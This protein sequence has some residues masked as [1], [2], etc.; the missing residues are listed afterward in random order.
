MSGDVRRWLEV[1]LGAVPDSFVS[2]IERYA[3]GDGG[4][5]SPSRDG[6][7]PSGGPEAGLS[8]ELGDRGVR[9]LR[10]ALERPGRD[11]EAA[12]RLLAADAYLTWAC[13]AAVE[14]EEPEAAL[15]GL[16]DRVAA[17]WE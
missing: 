4:V 8:R 16:L 2:W 17:E 3:E 7:R 5:E 11:R 1:R 12:F 10:D 14:R 15:R 9:A 6:A 13:E